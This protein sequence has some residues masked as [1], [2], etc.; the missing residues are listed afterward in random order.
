LAPGSESNHPKPPHPTQAAVTIANQTITAIAAA[1][2]TNATAA[3]LPPPNGTFINQTLTA[4]GNVSGRE[5]RCADAYG[6]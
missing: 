2:G 5:G 1:N 6:S 4:L 3:A